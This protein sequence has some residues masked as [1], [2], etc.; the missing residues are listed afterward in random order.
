MIKLNDQIITQGNFPD[1]TLLVKAIEVE[2]NC[3]EIAFTWLYENDAELFT[4][5]CLVDKYRIIGV[6][7]YLALPYIPHARMDRTKNWQDVFTLKTFC[8]IING[9]GFAGVVVADP[10]S[11][12]ST[13]LLDNVA[14]LTP[15]EII[16]A[17][18][19]GLNGAIDTEDSVFF[20]PDAGAAKRYN[21]PRPSTY[22]IKKRNWETGQ[23]ESLE[24][25]NPEAI[26]GK[27][28]VIVDDI[29]SYGGTFSRAAAALKAAGAQKITLYVTHCEKNIFKGTV[30]IDGN[31]DKVVT[32]N[33]ILQT[34]DVPE[35]LK[36][37][38][39]IANIF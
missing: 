18:G 32:T 5:Q 1:G 34:S 14:V 36:D 30:F 2:P 20:Y 24:I 8:K 31:V 17:D 9:M 25:A 35:E 22:G 38:V 3:K 4:L 11:D 12:V 28:V 6:P 26:N 33:S 23:I 39:V 29:C 27:N 16:F 10:H 37:K 19:T 21:F 7:M 15:Q 13:A